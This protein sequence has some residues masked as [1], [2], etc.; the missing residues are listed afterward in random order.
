[1]SDPETVTT[2]TYYDDNGTPIGTVGRYGEDWW[3]SA[4]G[5]VQGF[6]DEAAADTWVR[7][8]LGTWARTEP[9]RD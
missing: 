1:V 3:G 4:N 5:D 8:E 9:P 7:G 2:T 6:P